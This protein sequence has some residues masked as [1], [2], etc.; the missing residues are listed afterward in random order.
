MCKDSHVVN[1]TKPILAHIA[2]SKLQLTEK[3]VRPQH[4]EPNE[5]HTASKSIDIGRK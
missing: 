2:D 3:E 5:K 1:E 4:T